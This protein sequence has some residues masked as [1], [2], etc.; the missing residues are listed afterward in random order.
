MGLVETDEMWTSDTQ[1]MCD[2]QSDGQAETERQQ[3]NVN[4]WIGIWMI[5]T[6]IV[7]QSAKDRQKTA[8]LK[9]LLLIGKKWNYVIRL[10]EM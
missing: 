10:F 4:G 9:R 2:R 5:D 3:C 8:P 1:T 6:E 7:G